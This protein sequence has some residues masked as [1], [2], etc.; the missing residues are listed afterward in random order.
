MIG[1]IFLRGVFALLFVLMFNCNAICQ[2]IAITPAV[3]EELQI[4]DDAKKILN[5]KL[6][7]MATKNGFG[8]IGGP[9]VL[10]ANV[11]TVDKTVSATV[12]PQF[13]ID[14]EVSVCIINISEQIL[15]SETSFN[16]RGMHASEN[17]AYHMAVNRVNAGSPAVKQFMAQSR[18]K[19][20]D[21]YAQRVPAIM[22]KAQSL[23]DRGEY[24][25][26][27]AELAVIPECLSEY[28]VVADK[29]VTMYTA[30]IDRYADM[31]IQDA[32]GKIALRDYSGALEALMAVDPKS[33]RFN[34]A[35]GMVESIK[36]TIDAQEQAKLQAQMEKMR[37]QQ[38]LA[39][40]MHDDEVMLRKMQIEA[41][42]H[43]AAT[44]MVAVAAGEVVQGTLS[45]WLLGNL[46]N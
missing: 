17:K 32:K 19:I 34:T 5:Q 27:V 29:M 39:Q 18:E 21:Y 28:P 33:T 14:L 24:E 40:K 6:L 35:S 1:R 42:Q 46:I 3:C 13:I 44:Q 38:E 8:A 30:M 36:Q 37:A 4:P 9:F 12:P 22:A 15:V 23:S 45:K 31:A 20:I 43:T 25:A 7:Q 2:I 26:A 10:T 11:N 41:A 16:V